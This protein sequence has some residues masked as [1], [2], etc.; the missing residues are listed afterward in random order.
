M[1]KL[2]LP[3]F[4]LMLIL[5]GILPLVA[6]AR[7]REVFASLLQRPDNELRLIGLASLL[8]GWVLFMMV[9]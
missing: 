1:L 7:W 8:S 5:E 3:A 4:A 2:L 6:P 9:I